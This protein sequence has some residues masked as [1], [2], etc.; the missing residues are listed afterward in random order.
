MST[1]ATRSSRTIQSD[2]S[3]CGGVALAYDSLQL[4]TRTIVQH[5][6]LQAIQRTIAFHQSKSS[7]DGHRSRYD[8][9]GRICRLVIRFRSIVATFENMIP[10]YVTA[11]IDFQRKDALERTVQLAVLGVLCLD[12]PG[13]ATSTVFAMMSTWHVISSSPTSI[14]RV[15]TSSRQC[16][17]PLLSSLRLGGSR[18]SS[19]ILLR[20]ARTSEPPPLLLLLFL[21]LL[22][23]FLRTGVQHQPIDTTICQHVVLGSQLRPVRLTVPAHVVPR[24]IHQEQ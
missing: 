22:G 16:N 18:R 2:Q 11:R 19:M 15:S 3:N 4:A 12:A 23:L 5:T 8:L 17:F 10:M 14:I 9:Q 6:T 20:V 24:P 1:M 7:L 21:L 13:D